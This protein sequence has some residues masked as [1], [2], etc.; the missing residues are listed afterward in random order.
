[1]TRRLM[2]LRCGEPPMTYR[3]IAHEM[4]SSETALRMRAAR[5]YRTVRQAWNDGRVCVTESNE[6]SSIR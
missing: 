4:G 6:P 2:A 1:L 3:Q 5:F